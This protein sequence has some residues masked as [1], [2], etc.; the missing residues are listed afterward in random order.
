[1]GYS[2]NDE[3]SPSLMICFRGY[4][5]PLW[6]VGIEYNRARGRKKIKDWMVLEAAIS[7]EMS[8]EPIIFAL[9]GLHGR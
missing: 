4:W 1:M 2:M 8:V 5:H 7:M 6:K 3:I 9:G